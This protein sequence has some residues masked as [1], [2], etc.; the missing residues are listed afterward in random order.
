[1]VQSVHC[2]SC[3]PGLFQLEHG[4]SPAVCPLWLPLLSLSLS[5]CWMNWQYAGQTVSRMLWK[6]LAGPGNCGWPPPSR[7]LAPLR[8]LDASVTFV[9]SLTLLLSVCQG[10]CSRFSPQPA[11]P[12]NPRPPPPALICVQNK[13]LLLERAG[14]TLSS[15]YQPLKGD[16]YVCC[17]WQRERERD[18]TAWRAVWCSAAA[19][20]Q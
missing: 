12:P 14:R 3:R 20:I 13:C 17:G 6:R 19:R 16:Y 8:S 9:L 7:L 1:M 4:P 15:H 2:S 11:H 5:C 10:S 18:S